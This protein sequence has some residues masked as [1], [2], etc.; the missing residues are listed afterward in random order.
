MSASVQI[1]KLSSIVALTACAV[2]FAGA[3][4]PTTTAR[5]RSV[6][7]RDPDLATALSVVVPGAGQLY[8]GRLGKGL[9]IVGGSAAAIA[10]AIDA[11][12][13]SSK[14]DGSNTSST[15]SC[16]VTGVQTTAIVAGVLVWGYGWLTAGR[17]ARM[18]NAQ[19][20]NSSFAPFLDRQNGRLLAGL[21]LT[22]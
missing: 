16:R 22:R 11:N 18:R 7:Y 5:V 12:Q 4:Q 21:T 2:S 14:C 19:M 1:K 6:Q 3:Q 8:A 13:H 15:G 9:A 10:I 20:L 17:D